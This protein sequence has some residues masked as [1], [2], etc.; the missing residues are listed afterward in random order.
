MRY[1][2]HDL[3]NGKSA[4]VA[5]IFFSSDSTRPAPWWCKNETLFIKIEGL[6]TEIKYVFD[7]SP[8]T[9][10]VSKGFLMP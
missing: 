1:I 5:I 6:K 2:G 8:K 3:P 10:P 7:L 4:T 9:F